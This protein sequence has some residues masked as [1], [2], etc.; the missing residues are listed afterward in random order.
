VKWIPNF[1]IVPGYIPMR[2]IHECIEELDVYLYPM[3]IASAIPSHILS[4]Q[5]PTT[6]LDL[7]CSPGGKLVT[8]IDSSRTTADLSHL[9]AV[10]VDISQK[11]LE[12]CQSILQSYLSSQAQHQ[13]PVHQESDL[14]LPRVL[15]FCADGT[16]FSVSHQGQL[17]YDS[18][19]GL[20]EIMTSALSG[21]KRQNKSSRGRARKK[22]K[23]L[24][25]QLQR[26]TAVDTGTC[27]GATAP[28]GDD[29]LTAMTLRD[30][31]VV[32]VD[33]QCTHDSSYRH[34]RYDHLAEG[35]VRVPGQDSEAEQRKVTLIE[36]D[37]PQLPVGLSLSQVSKIVKHETNV[38]ELLSLQRGL[39]KNGFDLLRSGG[40][41]VYSTCSQ[42]R[43]QNEDIV[44]WLLETV[45]KSDSHCIAELVPLTEWCG[46]PTPHPASEAAIPLGDMSDSH[47]LVSAVLSS[48]DEVLF[49]QL[50]ELYHAP[51][52]PE[53]A[54]PPP[55]QRLAQEVCRFVASL[56]SPC[57]RCGDLPETVYFG[58]DGGTSGLYLARILKRAR[59][60]APPT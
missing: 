7:C 24:Q 6:S 48:A 5:N 4:Q 60:E 15:L 49:E 43:A 2:S 33:A 17:V 10:G 23:L 42:E 50:L 56:S 58:R 9:L 20:E 59:D 36:G 18:R 25:S 41:M 35:S 53:L 14:S 8:L 21:R 28:L 39:A 16:Q 11:R 57:G 31:D 29:D 27:A 38:E 55:I 44:Q 13:L 30:F 12:I 37:I 40:T 46:S 19:V 22:L 45:E 47:A 34:M 32:L 52:S 1:L 26:P 51:P 54:S 3:D